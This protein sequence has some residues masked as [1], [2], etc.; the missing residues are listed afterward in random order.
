VVQPVIVGERGPSDKSPSSRPLTLTERLL[1]RQQWMLYREHDRR[2]V[3]LSGPVLG[4]TACLATL[5]LTSWML[6]RDDQQVKAA[7]GVLT[8]VL[9]VPL[10]T[11]SIWVLT[12]RVKKRREIYR[13]MWGAPPVSSLPPGWHF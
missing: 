1:L 11:A 8:G 9:V 13:E 5:G 7:G 12:R 10:L 6:T 4:L 3:N 2:A